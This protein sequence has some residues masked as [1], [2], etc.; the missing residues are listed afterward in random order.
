MGVVAAELEIEL[1]AAVVMAVEGRGKMYRVMSIPVL[2]RMQV[3]LHRSVMCDIH[4]VDVCMMKK[5]CSE[6]K[7]GANFA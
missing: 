1:L 4:I 5:L 2:I 3:Q 7:F 6:C